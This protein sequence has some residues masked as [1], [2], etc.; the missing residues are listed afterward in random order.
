VGAEPSACILKFTTLAEKVLGRIRA[1]NLAPASHN[2][3]S[4]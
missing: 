3:S 4:T 2:R 1:G